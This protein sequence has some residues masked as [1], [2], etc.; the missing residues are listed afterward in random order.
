MEQ[1][2]SINR[3]L[4]ILNCFSYEKPE[5]GVTDISKQ[6]NLPK[7]TISRLLTALRQHNFVI[8]SSASQKFRLG[9]KILKLSGIVKPIMDEWV[10]LARP[11]LK[12]LRDKTNETTA[13]H[14]IDGDQRMC[15][16]E[17]PSLN[18]LR[19]FLSKG[20]HYP[21]HAGS[22]GKLLLAYQ[23]EEK[24][25]EILSKRKLPR[26]TPNTITNIQDLEKELSNIRQKGFALSY[27]ERAT[28][29]S[30]ISAPIRNYE[31]EVIAALCLHGPSMRLTHQKMLNF[32]YF[33]IETAAKISKEL[34]FEPQNGQK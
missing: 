10:V 1:M 21:L 22:A 26:F 25:K 23:S 19:P 32:K 3:A 14:V 34:G 24:R 33:V 12:D 4:E 16:E 2:K 30:S 28:F 15:I 9:M 29:L 13:L 27:Q 18:E 17:F 11:H 6:L 5:M 20:G 7:S 8:K 31:N